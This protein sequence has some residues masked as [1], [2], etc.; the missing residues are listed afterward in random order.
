[1]IGAEAFGTGAV[2]VVSVVRSLTSELVSRSEALAEVAGL[3]DLRGVSYVK[4]QG[5]SRSNMSR[6]TND[7]CRS[8]LPGR[9]WTLR[10]ARSSLL[11]SR[12]GLLFRS[13]PLWKRAGWPVSHRLRHHGSHRVG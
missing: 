6:Y 5:V 11:H 4:L 12:G 9:L 13:C 2:C 1:M 7:T 10:L 3:P 8:S